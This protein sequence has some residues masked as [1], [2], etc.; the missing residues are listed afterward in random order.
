MTLS[1]IIYRTDPRPSAEQVASVYRAS[2]LRRP[3]DD[4]PR[5]QGM[6]DGAN[7]VISAW[8]GDALVG[9]ARALTDFCF[10]CYLSDLAVDPTYQRQGIGK[11]LVRLVQEAI[12][13]QSMLLLLA[14]PEAAEYYPKI[15]F[16]A[17]LNGWMIQRRR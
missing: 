3:V 7:L 17:V 10:C 2:G 6:L 5:I 12:S 9:V 1:T 13:D 15:G 14:A 8:D 11:E 16:E 4:L